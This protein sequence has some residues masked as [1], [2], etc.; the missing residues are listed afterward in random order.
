M[1]I[2]NWIVLDSIVHFRFLKQKKI[3][4]DGLGLDVSSLKS[5]YEDELK[6]FMKLGLL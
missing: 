2:K 3:W 5:A 1:L 4:K 6:Q